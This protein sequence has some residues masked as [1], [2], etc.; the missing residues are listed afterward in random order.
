MATIRLTLSEDV[1]KLVSNI[2]FREFPEIAKDD[3]TEFKPEEQQAHIGYEIDLY[4]LYGGN[5]LLEDIAYILGRYDEHLPDTEEDA[6]GPKFPAETE[7]YMLGLHDFV[8]ENLEYIEEILHQ[9]IFKG[10]IKPGTYKCKDWQRIWEY[11][12]E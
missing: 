1:L 9:M 6:D 10:G 5:F 7:E 12:G 3:Q 11:V 8:V 4:S 2:R